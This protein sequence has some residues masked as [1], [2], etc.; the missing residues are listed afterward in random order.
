MQVFGTP[1]TGV[2]CGRAPRECDG[3]RWHTVPSGCPHARCK[4]RMIR[5]LG[6]NVGFMWDVV[7]CSC[8]GRGAVSQSLPSR[9]REMGRCS[10]PLTQHLLPFSHQG[11]HS[12]TARSQKRQCKATQSNTS[13]AKSTSVR[14]PAP[15]LI[16][17]CA[18][19]PERVTRELFAPSTTLS[20][21]SISLFF[22]YIMLHSSSVISFPLRALLFAQ[23]R[24]KRG[25]RA[26]VMG[27]ILFLPDPTH[28]SAIMVRVL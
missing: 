3:L 25:L 1:G 7:W 8:S 4:A 13:G 24:E 11:N 21:R 28:S 12:H 18:A 23:L 6:L 9:G 16:H 20:S 17:L 10:G 14:G 27:L 5:N 2:S 26:G 19:S 22:L 15:H